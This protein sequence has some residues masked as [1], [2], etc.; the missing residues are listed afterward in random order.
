ML[1]GELTVPQRQLS[2]PCS[3]PDS[4]TESLSPQS[5]AHLVVTE[6]QCG[7]RTEGL[8][9]GRDKE[10]SAFLSRSWQDSSS[11]WALVFL[12]GRAYATGQQFQWGGGFGS[13][14]HSISL[15]TPGVPGPTSTGVCVKD[16]V[17]M[18]V[19]VCVREKE[20]Q[21]ET[22]GEPWGRTEGEQPL[23]AAAGDSHPHRQAVFPRAGRRLWGCFSKVSEQTEISGLRESASK[24]S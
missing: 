1:E 9:E 2:S 18:C 24:S 20:K 6:V 23:P 17:S 5:P 19:K 15:P 10:E 12:L 11:S 16:S 14:G 8:R 22:Q 7:L 4:S 21:G 3:H 13:Q